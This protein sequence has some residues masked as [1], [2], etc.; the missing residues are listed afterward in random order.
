[1]VRGDRI[2]NLRVAKHYTLQELGD[3]IGVSAS[4]VRKWE[5]GLIETI[6]SDKIDKL[7]RAL[8]VAPG[9]LLDWI[10]KPEPY[11]DAGL[12]D[13]E[14]QTDKTPL[15]KE[16]PISKKA[17]KIGT[18]LFWLR[19]SLRMTQEELGN[20]LGVTKATINKYE[21]GAVKSIKRPM[22]EALAKILQTTPEFIT[23]QSDDPGRPLTLNDNASK[24]K[25]LQETM[26][27]KK[28]PLEEMQY[29][30]GGDPG[31]IVEVNPEEKNPFNR[32]ITEGYLRE[33][34]VLLLKAFRS[35]DLRRRVELLHYAFDLESQK[36]AEDSKK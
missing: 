4:T 14:T 16:E 29:I 28:H 34:E 17:E 23:G 3:K 36:R 27:G 26:A 9:Y 12:A 13:P 6:R 5:N 18:R 21:S 25:T 8:D 20:K 35:L 11:R 30:A 22:V 31:A 32:V 1:M 10:D 19:K 33:E 15:F 2:Y 7:A 24:S